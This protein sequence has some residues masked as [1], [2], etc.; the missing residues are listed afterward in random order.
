MSVIK[1][2]GEY[3][4]LVK[5]GV[6]NGDKII[7]AVRTA[8]KVKEQEKRRLA[9]NPDTEPEIS[10]EAVAEIM[11]RKEICAACPFNSENAAKQRSY[12]SSL[13]FIH[14]TLCKCRIGADDS[15]EYCLSCTCGME[16]WN[17]QNPHL[18]PMEPK[19]KAFPTN[20]Q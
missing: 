1:T 20:Q 6:K 14:C 5:N 17:N 8:A 4:N 19:W 10:D 7:E 11:R 18:T 16:V 15:K 9:G 2:I 3:V 12:S 13:P